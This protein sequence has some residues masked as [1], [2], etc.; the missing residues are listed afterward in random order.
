MAQRSRISTFLIELKRRRVFR[1]AAVYGGVAFVLFQIIDSIFEPLHIPEWIGSLIIVLLLLGFPLAVGLA[2]VFDI[3]PEGIVRTA[4]RPTGKPG[5]SNRTLIAVTILAVA[6]GIWGRWGGSAPKNEI[7]SI[8]VLALDNQ[9]ND[10]GLQYFV[11]GMHDAIISALTRLPDLR[12]IGRTSVLGY[13]NNPKP[14]PQIGQELGVDA[15]IEGSVLLEG[16][17]VRI[18]AQLVGTQP[19]RHLWANQFDRPL[20]DILQLYNDVATA[21]AE[22]IKITLTPEEAGRLT[23]SETVNPEAHLAYLKGQH[24]RRKVSVEGIQKAL[25]YFNEAIAIDPTYALAYVGLANTYRSATGWM[26]S[27]QEAGPKAQAALKMA[28]KLGP[29]YAEVHTALASYKL[30]FEWD[31][32][33][34][35]QE[36]L[37]ASAIDKMNGLGSFAHFLSLMGRHDEALQ[38]ANQ[39]L[40]ADPLSVPI[41]TTVAKAYINARQ[42]QRAEELLNNALELEQD[43]FVPHLDLARI[44]VSSGY[45]KKAVKQLQVLRSFE[46]GSDFMGWHGHAYG[47]AS[48]SIQAEAF[49]KS[50]M[51][52]IDRGDPNNFH[53]SPLIIAWVYIGLD[54]LEAAIDWLDKAYTLRTNWLYEIK[55]DPIYDPL[56]SHPRFQELLAKMN[57]PD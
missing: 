8:A 31:W 43:A 42:F 2:W 5:I 22:E 20:E 37:A 12:V 23:V 40:K 49:L 44:Y 16:N 24:H 29:G 55:V 36:F 11:D 33:G 19:E 30:N 57:F 50:L 1:V 52:F 21:I 41:I 7:R 25:Q 26:F 15:V 28:T 47:V 54:Q 6:F 45:P 48:D 38:K 46:D 32:Q 9:M 14:I 56:R 18:S 17:N 51:E 3:T 35:E 13:R 34:A 53:T 10:P 4:G 27:T 39:A